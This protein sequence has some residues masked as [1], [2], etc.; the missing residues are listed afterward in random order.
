M[1][2]YDTATG[3][4][5]GRKY[6]GCGEILVSQETVA[7]LAMVSTAEVLIVINIKKRYKLNKSK[8]RGYPALFAIQN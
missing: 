1:N 5:E 8:G 3:L 6:S 4:V 2:Y 7:I